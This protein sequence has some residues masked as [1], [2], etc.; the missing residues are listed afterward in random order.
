MTSQNS[1]FSRRQ[2][3]TQTA[4][5]GAFYAAAN[6]I[7]LKAMA[8]SLADDPRIAA[9]PLVDAGFASVR[10]IGGGLY[11]TISDTSKGLTTM[12]N[13]GFVAGKDSAL[14]LE[15]FVTPAGAAF[16]M[17]ALRKVSQVPALGALD[18]HYHYDH[19]TGNSYYGANGIPLWAQA[20]VGQRIVESYAPMQI[21]DK[22]TVL[23]PFERKLNSA[24]TDAVKQH[25]ESDLRAVG[26]IFTLVNKATLALPNRPIEPSKLP[27]KLDLGSLTVVIESYPGHSGTDLIVRVPE[28]KVVYSGD[29]VFNGLYPACFDEKATI[30]GWRATLKTFASWEKD[31][32]FVP[33]HGNVCGQEAV[34][35]MRDIFDDISEQA[36][37]MRKAGV[38]VS[39]A[40]DLYVVPE[41]FK[42]YYVFAWDLCIGSAIR[43][44]YTEMAAN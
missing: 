37:K 33:G 4:Y 26:N 5:F 11:A 3:I 25:A 24:K 12:C 6:A 42:N 17:D 35:T 1:H 31:T 32:I 16:Q 40:T 27:M 44:L 22:A 43:K 34:Q 21:A 9:T 8:E 30:S 15:G 23:A 39:E 10:K 19:S 7:P 41:K 2:F 13:G 20:T 29:L 28:Q 38:P 36:D 14:L 18:T